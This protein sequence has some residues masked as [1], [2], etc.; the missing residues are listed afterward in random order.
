M[1]NSSNQKCNANTNS[2][3]IPTLI[4]TTFSGMIGLA[5]SKSNLQ[6]N[7]CR[8]Q[9][10]FSDI[11]EQTMRS[12]KNIASALGIAELMQAAQK[13]KVSFFAGFHQL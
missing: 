2:F 7:F 9:V 3:K 6:T 5:R 11:K 1:Q 13:I 12:L 4:G 10:R 8:E